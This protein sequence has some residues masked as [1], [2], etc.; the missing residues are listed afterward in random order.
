MEILT[1]EQHHREGKLVRALKHF[2]VTRI[3][4][5]MLEYILR[6]LPTWCRHIGT[7][8]K[9]TCIKLVGLFSLLVSTR[10]SRNISLSLSSW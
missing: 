4:Q 3:S 5:I 1:L 9:Y 8:S 7:D 6:K 10:L 2:K